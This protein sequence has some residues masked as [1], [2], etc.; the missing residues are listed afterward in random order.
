V[1]TAVNSANALKNVTG[2]IVLAG[3]GK[4]GSAMLSGK[5]LPPQASRRSSRSHPGRSGR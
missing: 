2:S 5:G 4:M 1:V 3:A